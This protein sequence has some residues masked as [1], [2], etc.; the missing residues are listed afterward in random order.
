MAK[1]LSKEKESL[2]QRINKTLPL[3]CSHEVTN[4][5]EYCKEVFIRVNK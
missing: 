5:N 3:V 2:M 4:S 1:K